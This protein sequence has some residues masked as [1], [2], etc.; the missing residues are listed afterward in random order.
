MCINFLNLNISFQI[1]SL[2]LQN[3]VLKV[4]ALKFQNTAVK[5][6]ESEWL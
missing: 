5:D 1:K 4:I 3:N 2:E 6:Q